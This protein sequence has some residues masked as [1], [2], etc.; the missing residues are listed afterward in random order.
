M[1]ANAI[2][3]GFLDWGDIHLYRPHNLSIT[4]LG[5]EELLD[6]GPSDL[7]AYTLDPPLLPEKRFSEEGKVYYEDVAPGDYQVLVTY[8]D[9]SWARLH[10]RLD[11]GK[12]HDFDFKASGHRRLDIRVTDAKGELLSFVPAVLVSAREENGVFVVRMKAASRDGCASFEGIRATKAQVWILSPDSQTLATRDVVFDSNMGLQVEVKVG[13]RPFRIHVVDADGT[14]LPGAWVTVRSSSGSEI[15]GVDDTDSE[16]WAS[17][18]GLPGGTVLIDVQHGLAGSCF[19]V[20][21]DPSEDPF[22]F[23]LEANGSIELELMDGEE[24]L[25]GVMTRIETTGGV[26]LSDAKQTNDQGTVR[27]EPLGEGSY[28]F[29]CRR[30]DC[31]PVVVERSL[32]REDKARV[33]VQMRQLADLELQVLSPDGIPVSDAEVEV[34]STEFGVALETWLREEKIRAPGGLTTDA[35]GK[36]R[37]EGLPR[38]KYTWSVQVGEQPLTGSSELAPAKNNEIVVHLPP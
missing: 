7:R 4:L 17:L 14:A 11:P 37:V 24:R 21:V 31:W 10:I 22:E 3:D 15:H 19:G 6:F 1:R 34:T 32:G 29:A 8:P 9:D 13:S 30:A 33:P 16:G 18:F 20:P 25:A 38:G 36:I 5:L 23:V 26:T 28:R 27:F 2:G 12:D 35:K